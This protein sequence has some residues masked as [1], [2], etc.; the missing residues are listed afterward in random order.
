[1][2]AKMSHP[3]G[4]FQPSFNYTI[5]HDQYPYNGQVPQLNINTTQQT[6]QQWQSHRPRSVQELR[7]QARSPSGSVHIT[8]TAP[9]SRLPDHRGDHQNSRS[10]VHHGNERNVATDLS[11]LTPDYRGYDPIARNMQEPSWSV[12]NP[13]SSNTSGIRSPSRQSN[14]NYRR[15]GPG[16]D[17][18]SQVLPSDEGYGSFMTDQSLLSNE[19]GQVGLELPISVSNPLANMSLGPTA[20]E[21]AVRPRLPSDQ[22]SHTSHVSSRSGKSSKPIECPECKEVSKCNSDFK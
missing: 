19:P 4:S 22:R 20:I 6:Q 15:Y 5:D 11:Y 21:A 13:R 16:S 12:Y 8:R 1:V 2:V 18:D 17:I 10:P 9:N 3:N 7:H 14:A